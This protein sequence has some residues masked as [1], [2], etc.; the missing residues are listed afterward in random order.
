MEALSVQDWFALAGLTVA[1]GGVA[2]FLAGLLGIGGGIVLVP[3]LYFIF[4][5]LGFGDEYMMHMAVGTSLAVIIPTGLASARAHWRKG[6]VRLDLV[7]SIGIGIVIGVLCGTAIADRVDTEMLQMIFAF[8]TLFFGA[9]IQIDPAKISRIKD[10][11]RQPWPAFVG[12]IIGTLSSLM[13]V[14][15]A[16]MNVPFLTLCGVSIH[17][18]IGTAS[19]I[20]PL[21]AFPGYLGFIWIGLGHALQLGSL[22]YIHIPAALAIIPASVLMAPYGAAAAH[23]A[24]VPAMRRIFAGF[25]VIVAIKML[26]EAFYG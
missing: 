11:P 26:H 12:A 16:T 17:K 18:A 20:G 23:R 15:G 2:G 24:S 6:N 19:A 25:L 4:T 10:V 5:C 1:L 22:G 8:A 3:G 14:G 7:R 9:L 21:I 13:G